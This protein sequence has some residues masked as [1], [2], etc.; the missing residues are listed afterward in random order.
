MNISG[1]YINTYA[2]ATG[3]IQITHHIYAD[4][5]TTTNT[6]HYCYMTCLLKNSDT[7][8]SLVLMMVSRCSKYV[9]V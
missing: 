3:T 6:T 1:C 7:L 5:P 2:Y 9:L 4:Q 8:T